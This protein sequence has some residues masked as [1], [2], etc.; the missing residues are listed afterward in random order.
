MRM[1]LVGIVAALALASS[2]ATAGVAL[3]PLDSSVELM[4]DRLVSQQ[5][6]NGSWAGEG[7]YT[8]VIVAGLVNAYQL[9]GRTA[10]LDAAERGGNYI[11]NTMGPNFYGDGAYG[12]SR[13]SQTAS[14]TVNNPWREAL[15]TYYQS[16]KELSGGTQGY[17]D[18]FSATEPSYATFYLA[19]HTLTAYAV[20]AA[21]KTLWRDGLVSFLDTVNDSSTGMPVFALGAAVQALAVTGPL[22]GALADLPSRLLGHQVVSGENAGSFYWRFDHTSPPGT[23]PSGFTEDAIYG[24]LGLLAADRANPSLAYDDNI[25]LAFQALANGVDSDDGR[26]Y[27]HLWS[28]G[29]SYNTYAGEMLQLVYRPGDLNPDVSQVTALPN[30]LPSDGHFVGVLEI[31]LRD[32]DGSGMEGLAASIVVTQTGAGAVVVG[33]VTEI[34]GG[35]YRASLTGTAK[36]EVTLTVT[37]GGTVLTTHPQVMVYTQGE[38]GWPV[39]NAGPD[40]YVTDLDHSGDEVIILNGSASHDNEGPI[41]SW[42]WFLNGSQ[43]ASDQVVSVTLAVGVHNIVLVVEDAEGHIDMDEVLVYVNP[44]LGITASLDHDWVYQNTVVTTQDRHMCTLTVRVSANALA[45][46]VYQI[47]SVVEAG[48]TLLNFRL[49]PGSLP[50][51]LELVGAELV[52]QVDILGGRRGQSIASAPLY[53]VLTITV[54]GQERGQVATVNVPLALRNLADINGDGAVTASDKLEMNKNLNG[55]ATLPGIGLR[56]LDLTG[57]GTTVNAEDKLVINQ[58]LNGLIVP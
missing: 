3:G 27:E 25:L 33:L 34:G 42:L 50:A 30:E 6:A 51:V 48:G 44:P 11:L 31:L 28:G 21:D 22:D 8:G 19:Q 29:M 49:E 35:L 54:T 56:E 5:V 55:L 52:G 53:H 40:Q 39:A 47:T 9:T 24:T 13:L 43:I 41:S 32:G 14:D 18:G 16:V 7:D 38:D 58:V 26:V 4:A 37:V 36:G 1:A 45:G 46:E 10:Y 20:N 12:L 23:D 17:I 15:V 57:D 2:V